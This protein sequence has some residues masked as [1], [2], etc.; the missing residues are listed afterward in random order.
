M[1]SQHDPLSTFKG[2][3]LGTAIGL[4]IW[5]PIITLIWHIIMQR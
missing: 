5:L 4:L 2:I 3:M 1:H